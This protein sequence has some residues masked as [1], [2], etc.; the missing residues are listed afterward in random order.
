[1]CWFV[2]GITLKTKAMK[3]Q[4]NLLVFIVEDDIFYQEMVKN[5][6]KNSKHENIEVFTNG[7]DCINN[8]NK[9]PDI[10][11]LDY[12]LDDSMNGI[13]VLKKIKSFNPNIQV[14]MFSA[15]EKLDVAINSMK[16]GAYD[17]IIKNEVAMRRVSQMVEK[18]CNLNGLLQENAEF[19]KDR[20]LFLAGIGVIAVIVF[21]LGFLFPHYF[22]I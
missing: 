22:N 20:N 4:S 12:N 1:M 15:Q 8:L 11:M 2:Y 14:I 6:L 10:I 7:K 19:K 18:I 21:L 3:T 5:E 16:Y 17:Y 13:E 9:M